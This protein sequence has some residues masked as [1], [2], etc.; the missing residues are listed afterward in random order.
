MSNLVLLKNNEPL[1]T[2]LIVSEQLKR[3]HKGIY[4]L[5]GDYEKDFT[6]LGVLR[7]ETA[8]P[9]TGRPQKFYYLNE[10]QLTFLIMMLRVKRKDEKDL[11]LKFK[12][13]IT[14]EFFRTRQSLLEI[15]LNHKNKEWLE[16][17]TDGKKARKEFTNMLKKL[18]EMTKENN[19]DSYYV[20]NP[21]YLYSNFTRM[22]YKNLFEYDKKIKNLRDLMSTK[23]L[24]IL[25][26]AEYAALKIIH[27]GITEKKDAKEI[28]NLTNIQISK[29]IEYF[30]KTNII[31]I[32]TNNQLTTN[33]IL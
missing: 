5:I 19:P 8:K 12:K 16:S 28:Y 22:I 3:T 24:T 32:I 7:F 14:Q 11:V 6:E 23:Q 10:Q 18:L 4:E 1:T 9:K 13:L 29:Y 25:G 26:S 31:E 15:K 17:R 2:S 33:D 27:N 30:E 21:K 20:K